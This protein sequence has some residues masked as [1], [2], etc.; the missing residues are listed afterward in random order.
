MTKQVDTDY[1]VLRMEHFNAP[2]IILFFHEKGHEIGLNGNYW[3]DEV[4]AE[5]SYNNLMS[6][7]NR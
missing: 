4:K 2:S 3:Q 6:N 5:V 1:M 7:F